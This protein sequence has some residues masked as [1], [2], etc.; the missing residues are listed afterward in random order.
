MSKNTFLQKYSVSAPVFSVLSHQNWTGL[1][2]AK[3][4]DAGRVL[5]EARFLEPFANAALG[6]VKTLEELST[7]DNI[8][9][10]LEIAAVHIAE[11]KKVWFNKCELFTAIML[12]EQKAP[13]KLM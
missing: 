10:A 3:L 6:E 11:E 12:K 4:I 7:R 2:L 9:D 8:L 13:T 1:P 5:P